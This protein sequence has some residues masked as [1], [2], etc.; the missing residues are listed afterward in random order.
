MQDALPGWQLSFVREVLPTINM[1]VGQ[2][3]VKHGGG[4]PGISSK[5]KFGG[6]RFGSDCFVYVFGPSEEV[7][8]IYLKLEEDSHES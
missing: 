3:W 7:D 5:A 8:K 6:Q 2:S 4:G 1:I